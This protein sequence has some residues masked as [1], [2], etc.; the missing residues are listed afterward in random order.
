MRS[1]ARW[2]PLLGLL[3]ALLPPL[4]ALPETTAEEASTDTAEDEPIDLEKLHRE[5]T[6]RAVLYPVRKRISRYLEAAAKAVDTGKPEEGRALLEKLNPK[7]L[8]P[9]ERALVYR[10]QAHLAYFAGDYTG[11][12]ENFE[13]V[14]AEEVLPVRDE[15]RIRFN[16]AQL[17]ASNQQWKETLAALHRWER[18]VE[19]PDPL[20]L[21]L[22]G[23][24]HHQL[25][26]L[27]AA[28]TH[29][30]KA[31]D[32]AREPQ[33]SWLTLLA[34]L[35]ILKEDYPNAIRVLEQLVV[36]S[37][38]K[39]QYW[40]QLALVYGALEKYPQSL[41]VQ[42]IADQQGL[43]TEDKELRRL[44]RASLHQNL[45]YPAAQVL[46]KGLAAGTIARDAAALELLANSWIAAREYEKALPPLLEAAKLS[47]DGNLYARLGQ[48]YMQRE[49]WQEASDALQ[50]AIEKGKLRD[51]G[52]AQL[53]LGIAL[54]NDQR[55]D[56]ARSAFARAR[57]Q[58]S[59]RAAAERW[60]T[61]L[62]GDSG[63]G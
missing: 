7:R 12:R 29:T 20:A 37:P 8:N 47:P 17:H 53:L 36:R 52:N 27:D 58:E 9:L 57:Q 62:D 16:I 54:F 10:L 48:V 50:K 25:G 28:L 59:T 63:A 45:P 33:E 24:A 13:K 34:A 40:V 55:V 11:A 41:A 21:Y 31:V 15:N 51:L 4:A 18:Y 26:E 61:H 38:T 19:E 5:R 14:L 35:Y 56:Q 43:L 42:Q 23:I 6:A 2:L 60:I 22:R 46:E 39:R 32:L 44:A 49:R 3:A 1:G 30:Q